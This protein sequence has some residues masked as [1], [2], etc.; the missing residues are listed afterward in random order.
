MYYVSVIDTFMSGWGKAEGK[1]NVL[2]FECDTKVEAEIVVDNAF[3]RG[4]TGEVMM[5][6]ERPEFDEKKYFVQTKTKEDYPSWYRD[7][8]FS[9][10][11]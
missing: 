2:V 3:N 8:Y 4:D 10:D 7:G 6:E 11:E 5:Y 9:S 1:T